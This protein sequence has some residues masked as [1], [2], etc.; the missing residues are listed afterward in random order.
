MLRRIWEPI[1]GIGWER[2]A[3]RVGA[4]ASAHKAAGRALLFAGGF[5]LV[6]L[7]IHREVYSF[8]ARR[9]QY[10]VPEIR[11]AVAPRWAEK[12][13][14]E[15]VRVDGPGSSLFDPGLVGRVGLA[16]ESCPWIRRV[17]AV[18]R[19]FPDQLR[20]RFEYRHAHVAV[21]RPNGYVLV[22]EEGIRLPGVF[23]EPPACERAS[24]ITGV[25]SLPS[26]PGKKW[27]DPALSEAMAMAEYVHSNDLLRR[28]GVRE[29][30]AANFGGRA[31]PRRS[32]LTLVT[33]AG[34]EL[35]WGRTPATARFGDASSEEKLENLR[36]VMAAYPDLNG[37]RRVKLYF[38]GARAVEVM[39]THANARKPK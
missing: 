33:R 9:P 35:A 22:D 3:A 17:V 4:V 24:V 32:E 8:I 25:A 2:I 23:V 28:L 15:M 39:D 36:E 12:Y 10:S 18:E 6:V 30:D 5:A 13:G 37:L 34:C 29:I 38:R 21:R 11:S 19:V 16:F 14:V 1:R 20:V 26:E 31:D 7:L 27:D